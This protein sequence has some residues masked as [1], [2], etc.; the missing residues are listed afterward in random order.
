SPPHPPPRRAREDQNRG[1][2]VRDEEADF[3]TGRLRPRL[4][5]ELKAIAAQSS[6]ISASRMIGAHLRLSSSMSSLNSADDCPP[7]SS[8]CYSSASR[9]DGSFSAALTSALI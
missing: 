3:A 2:Y 6:L 8:P 5:P 4:S 9:T 7:G 1:S